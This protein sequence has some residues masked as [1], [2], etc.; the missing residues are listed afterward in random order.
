MPVPSNRIAVLARQN[1]PIFHVKDLAN[2]WNIKSINTLYVL[3]KRY[4]ARG[5]LFRIYKGFY[6]F[7][8]PEK[9]DPLL[10]GVKALHSY[11]Y[12]STE[13]VL[14][15]E[16]LMMQMTYGHTLISSHSCHFKIGP[17][18]FKSRKLKDNYLYNPAGIF[19][20]NG[21]LKATPERAVADLLYFNPKA[22]FDGMHLVDFKKVRS[23]QKEIGYP[24][25]PLK[26]ATP[27]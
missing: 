9:L 3:L 15:E 11:A 5:L 25:M 19:E 6:S 18:S 12:V 21:I 4:A 17:Y 16:G 24:L 1:H 27:S 23:I 10:L 26:N 14:V 8:P 2:L 13:T 22:Y 20:E 7:L